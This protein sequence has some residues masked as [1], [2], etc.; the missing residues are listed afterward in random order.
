MHRMKVL[1]RVNN[2][3][4]DTGVTGWNAIL[5]EQA[6]AI[7]L[8]ESQQCDFLIIGAGFAGLSAARRLSQL[9]PG[10]RIIVLEAK[11][12][13]EGPAGRNSGF[14]ID[15]PHDLSSNDYLTTQENDQKQITLNRQAIAFAQDAAKEYILPKEAFNICG[16]INGAAG[17][18]A[19]QHNFD[20]AKHLEA[21]GEPYKMLDAQGMKKLTGSSFYQSGI[22]TPGTAMV[23]PAIYIRGVSSGLGNKVS[24]FSNSPVVALDKQNNQWIAKTH[25]GSVT[26]PKVILATNG[27]IES[28]GYFKRRFVH[29]ILYAS[30]SRALNQAEADLTGIENWGITPSDPAAT[31]MRKISCSRGTRII[32]RNRISYAPDMKVSEVLLQQMERTHVKSFTKRYPDLSHV[33]QEYTW[34][35]RLCLSRNGVSA[36]GEV[37]QGLYSACCQNGLGLARGTLSGMAIAE[38]AVEGETELAKAFLAEDKPQK[39]PPA[40]LDTIGAN[41]FMRWSEFKARKEL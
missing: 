12:I 13:A 6:P 24:I 33:K 22:Y 35:G 5:E 39:L 23:Q 31:T 16:K 8:E 1:A 40:P 41:A 26:A 38:L 9:K 11:R 19:T 14:M 34:A 37:E 7:T 10:A 3:P 29:V 28:F 15:L 2:L 32:T 4:I 25:K 30:M 21:L 18:K 17:E 36:F 20:Y 27:H